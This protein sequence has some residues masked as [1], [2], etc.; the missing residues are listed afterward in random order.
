MRKRS[1]VLVPD[2]Q[3]APPLGVKLI[4]VLNGIMA[5]LC[6]GTAI[7]RWAYHERYFSSEPSWMIIGFLSVIGILFG[8]A[9][10]GLWRFKNWAWGVAFVMYSL[11]FLLMCAQLI[12][13][14]IFP[15]I[16]HWWH[17][18]LYPILLG[19][20]LRP[21]IRQRFGSGHVR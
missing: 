6:L 7:L 17:F 10:V 16:K 18:Y 5:F 8:V 9:T 3:N 19:Y 15:D 21:A 4:A 11:V 14:R 12:Q 2:K 20:L 13:H 1:M